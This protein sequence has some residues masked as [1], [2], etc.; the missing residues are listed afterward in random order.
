VYLRGGADAKGRALLA[1][2][3][4]RVEPLP[5]AFAKLLEGRARFEHGDP[6]GA[7]RTYGEAQ[8][9]ADTWLGRFLLGRA[10]L[11]AGAYLEAHAE[12]EQCIKRRGEA[13]DVFS[14]EV[15]TYA[16]FPP[17]LYYM[18]RAQEGLKSPADIESFEKFL[19]TK[20]KSEKD[21]LVD[22]ARRRAGR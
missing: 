15:Q 11:G 21:P 14:D 9:I 1:K 16:Y 5:Q 10:Y 8:K 18:G 20:A 22:D 12:L 3:A 7:I 17:A 19:A 4:A 6:R 13:T 2:L